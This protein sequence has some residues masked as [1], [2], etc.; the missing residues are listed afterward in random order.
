MSKDFCYFLYIFLSLWY[1][2]DM[3]K[4]KIDFS[5]KNMLTLA[6]L[7]DAVYSLRVREYLVLNYDLKPNALNKKANAV[8]CAKAQAEALSLIRDEL[9]EREADIV[10]RTRN[11]HL[12]TVAK[13]STL[14]EYSQ[15]T[16]FEALIGY[17][18]LE[19]EIDRIDYFMGK[20]IVERL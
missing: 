4:E 9:S 7:G 8:V 15:A 18:Y 1:I 10:R 2:Q 5:L 3:G 11:S 13:N 17:W 19:G 12:N 6:Y 16:Q 20:Y 14:A